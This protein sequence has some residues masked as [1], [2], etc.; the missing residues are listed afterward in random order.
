MDSIFL[1]DV[2]VRELVYSKLYGSQSVVLL[3]K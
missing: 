2:S 3:T 1:Y